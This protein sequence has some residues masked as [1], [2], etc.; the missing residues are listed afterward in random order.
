MDCMICIGIFSAKINARLLGMKLKVLAGWVSLA[1]WFVSLQTKGRMMASNSKRH[2]RQFW[3]FL[4]NMAFTYLITNLLHS[5]IPYNEKN[6]F[7]SFYSFIPESVFLHNTKIGGTISIF[8][9]VQSKCRDLQYPHCADR[10][11][12]RHRA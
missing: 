11:G 3:I 5:Y 1:L 9:H 8:I 6:L 2:S 12:K 7:P 4:R 10:I